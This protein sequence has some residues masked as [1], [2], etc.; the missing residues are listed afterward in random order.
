ML[1]I[2]ILS[3]IIKIILTLSKSLIKSLFCVE[4]QKNIFFLIGDSIVW[5]YKNIIT[6]DERQKEPVTFGN[7]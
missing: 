6:S 4:I 5:I 2:I 7:Y 1:N 3:K